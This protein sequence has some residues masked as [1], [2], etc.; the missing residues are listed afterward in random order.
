VEQRQKIRLNNCLSYLVSGVLIFCFVL[1]LVLVVLPQLP[2]YPNEP[3][4]RRLFVS[5]WNFAC[6]LMW[7]TVLRIQVFNEL[8]DLAKQKGFKRSV[9]PWV[10]FWFGASIFIGSATVTYVLNSFAAEPLGSSTYADV[11]TIISVV[12]WIALVALSAL[13]FLSR[14]KCSKKALPDVRRALS[15]HRLLLAPTSLLFFLS[16][17]LFP[18]FFLL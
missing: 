15:A 9:T 3:G 12:N 17:F 10:K 18:I 13:L 11:L 4:E 1:V 6:T 14:E 2:N 7:V 16:A 8:S 5:T